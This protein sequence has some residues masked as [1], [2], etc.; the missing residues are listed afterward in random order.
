MR[1]LRAGVPIEVIALWLGHERTETTN[2][3]LHADLSIKE[4]ALAG[5]RPSTFTLAASGLLT[6]CSP[7]SKHSD[8]ADC[9]LGDT[10]AD[11][12]QCRTIT[13]KSA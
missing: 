2:I 13:A 3:Y 1:L 12:G 7:S 5:Q 11:L 6:P 8:Y 9:S 4:R 10:P